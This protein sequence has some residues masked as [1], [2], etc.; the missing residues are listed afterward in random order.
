MQQRDDPVVAWLPNSEA[1]CELAMSSNKNN[2]KRLD[3]EQVLALRGLRLP[4]TALKQL[5]QTGIYCEPSVSIE[6][7]HLAQKYVIRGIESGG[8]VAKLGHYV[9]FVDTH[10][11]SLP[12]LQRVHSV[13]RNGLHAIV[14]ASQIVR[15]QMFRRGQT[16]EL[17]ITQHH[18]ESVHEGRRP[19]LQNK[20]IFHGVHGTLALDLWR[21]D[22]HFSGQV[23]P[24][25]L[26]RSGEPLLIPELLLEAV[27]RITAAASCVGCC[28]CHLLR[29]DCHPAVTSISGANI[30]DPKTSDGCS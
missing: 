25:F 30:D 6:H 5:Q 15:L 8:G 10:G 2:P 28:H 21:E 22:S 11:R 1:D 13:G 7:Q 20:V 4:A 17:L 26:I 14:V 29:S 16:Y 27:C 18:L 12:W 3:R 23:T 9:G 24:A 19:T